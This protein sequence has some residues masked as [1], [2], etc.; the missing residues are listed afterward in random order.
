VADSVDKAIKNAKAE[1]SRNPD[2]AYELLKRQLETVSNN[3]A[4]GERLRDRLGAQLQGQLRDVELRGRGIKLRLEQDERQGIQTRR[5]AEREGA[6]IGNLE[7]VRERIRAFVNLM[8][9]A[10][11]DEAYKEANLLREESINKGEPVPIEAT[12]AYAISLNAMNLKE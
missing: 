9:R 11:F 5:E 1:L 10:R 2:L 3:V 8:N 12:A 7:R 4:I 6:R